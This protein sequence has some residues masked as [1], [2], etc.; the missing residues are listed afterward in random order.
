M[1]KSLL[2]KEL[3][4]N[5]PINLEESEGVIIA[6]DICEYIEEAF[7]KDICIKKENLN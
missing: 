4:L 6:K 3:M 5:L 2:Y 1:A 7:N